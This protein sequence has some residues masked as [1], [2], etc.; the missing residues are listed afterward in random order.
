MARASEKEAESRVHVADGG[1]YDNSG[2]LSASEWL[3]EAQPE[4]GHRTVEFILIDSSSSSP[5][6]GQ[7]WSWQR[8]IVAPIGTLLGVR[9]S[10]QNMRAEYE[11]ELVRDDLRRQGF[12]LLT[13]R[14]PYPSDPLTP[15]SW[16]LTPEQER[17]IGKA[18]SSKGI[19]EQAQGIVQPLGCSIR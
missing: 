17:Q 18:W 15:L 7:R 14:L 19:R 10:S 4:I 1:Y 5:A 2:V 13:F 3:L 16:H 6:S 8:Q 12:D 9:T 11:L